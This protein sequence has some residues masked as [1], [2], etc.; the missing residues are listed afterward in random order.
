[1]NVK[2][3][4]CRNMPCRPEFRDISLTRFY[5]GHWLCGLLEQSKSKIKG[6]V[7]FEPNIHK[8]NWWPIFNWV[9]KALVQA[10]IEIDNTFIRDLR[11]IVNPLWGSL[12]MDLCFFMFR[13]FFLH[14]VKEKL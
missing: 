10:D 3:S 4:F 2:M 8:I 13:F 14:H 5:N 12:K 9:F 6:V 7:C 11:L 1:M